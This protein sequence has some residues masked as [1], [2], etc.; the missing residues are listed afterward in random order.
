METPP[1]CNTEIFKK[2]KSVVALDARSHA[3][4]KWV[5]AVAK[6][7]GVPVDWHYSGGIANV[8]YLGDSKA[9]AKVIKAIDKLEDSLD[10]EI[11]KRFEEEDPS[12]YRKGVTEAPEGSV[13]AF[14]EPGKKGSTFIK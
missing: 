8:L 10:G 6:E 5:K 3:A 12:L 11:W 4:E 14:Y 2:G 1:P 7:S 13:A 9:R